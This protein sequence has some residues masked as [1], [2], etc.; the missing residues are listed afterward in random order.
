M[1]GQLIIE[2]FGNYRNESLSVERTERVTTL[3]RRNLQG[4]NLRATLVL[5]NN[6]SVQHLNDYKFS[7]HKVSEIC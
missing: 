5:T 7:F 4:V 2:H 3:R 1:G 6:N